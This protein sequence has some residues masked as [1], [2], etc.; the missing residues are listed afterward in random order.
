MP[1]KVSAFGAV[2]IDHPSREKKDCTERLA[3]GTRLYSDRNARRGTINNADLVVGLVGRFRG[4]SGV[5]ILAF[6]MMMFLLAD[7]KSAEE[8]RII[9]AQQK[10]DKPAIVQSV[11]CRDVFMLRHGL[12][13]LLGHGHHRYRFR[14]GCTPISTRESPSQSHR[15]LE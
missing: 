8:S 6:S 12:H 2:S 14:L 4:R 10:V 1:C 3:E 5:G 7:D 9:I 13:N 11:G 15:G